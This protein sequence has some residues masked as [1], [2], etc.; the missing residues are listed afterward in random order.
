VARFSDAD[1]VVADPR[2]RA[3]VG[4]KPTAVLIVLCPPHTALLSTPCRCSFPE[5]HLHMY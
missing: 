4:M 1:L 2:S 3:K 5:P